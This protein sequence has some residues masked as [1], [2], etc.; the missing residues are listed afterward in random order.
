MNI[1][2]FLMR[3]AR[4]ERM[5]A[6]TKTASLNTRVDPLLKEQAETIL[7]EL[8]ISMSTAMSLF[9][10]Q[11]VIHNGLPFDVRLPKTAPT[12]YGALSENQF[13]GLMDNAEKSYSHGHC[14][15]LSDFEEQLSKEIDI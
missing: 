12:A 10:K 3:F 7:G 13:N 9:L 15:S 11:L 4:I 14:K 8:G 5:I 6:M 1:L 2:P